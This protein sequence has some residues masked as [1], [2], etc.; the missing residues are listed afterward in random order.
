MNFSNFL[1]EAVPKLKFLGSTVTCNDLV[2]DEIN[3]HIA[4]TSKSGRSLDGTLHSRQLSKI[5][6]TLIY[7]SIIINLAYAIFKLSNLQLAMSV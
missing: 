5:T 6:K 4:S 7:K 3:L 2:E 1:I